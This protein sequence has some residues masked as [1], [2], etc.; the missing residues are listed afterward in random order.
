MLLVFLLLTGVV[1][2]LYFVTRTKYEDIMRTVDE[3]E[4]AMKR[5]FPISL[6]ILELVDYKYSFKYDRIITGKVSELYG[7]RYSHIFLKIH[8]AN[9]VSFMIIALLFAFLLGACTEPDL[10]MAVFG[11][12]IICA[13]FIIPDRELSEKVKKRRISIQLDFP[14]FINKLILLVNAGMTVSRAWEKIVADNTKD[15]HIYKELETALFDIRAGKSEIQAYE[16]FARRCRVPQVTKFVSVVIQN[17]RKGNSELI[18]ILR[19]QANDCWEMRKN[20]AKKLGEE[21]STKM[22][23]PMMIMF[24][25]I[26]IIVA[27]PAILAMRG[28]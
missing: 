14:D 22:L 12:I 5:F 24:I 2:S 20:T 6:Y 25:A 18:P 11:V 16:D 17:I 13:A 27:V 26:L 23:I 28:I 7:N 1:F 15:G 9:K 21:A 4:Y 8:W 10:S 19:L 3:K